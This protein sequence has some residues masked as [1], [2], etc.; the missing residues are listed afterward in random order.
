M[1]PHT[2]WDTNASNFNVS[3]GRGSSE[4]DLSKAEFGVAA[5]VL[6][7]WRA[8]HQLIDARRVEVDRSL[9]I[10]DFGCGAGGFSQ[11]RDDCDDVVTG[12]DISAQML[13][14][15]RT[16]SP[17]HLYFLQGDLAALHLFR[18]QDVVVANLVTNYL[19]RL[20][21]L[22]AGVAR[23]LAPGAYFSLLL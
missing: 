6:I 8:I 18:H 13:D 1:T 14:C 4:L 10:I 3:P 21:P 2:P 5:N 22:A 23:A 20:E 16:N 9:H 17:R 11:Q 19:P 15:A 12:I 7:A